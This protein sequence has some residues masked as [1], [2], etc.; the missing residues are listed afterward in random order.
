MEVGVISDIL[1]GGVAIGVLIISI[2]ALSYVIKR[3]MDEAKHREEAE[4]GIQKELIEAN[5]KN[6]E[7]LQKV[8]D[9]INE[10]N[11]LNK[12]LSEKNK[13]LTDL[14]ENKLINICDNIEY[15]K[16]Y[17]NKKDID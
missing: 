6:S 15:I 13:I 5:E 3:I 16:S 11:N 4:R 8:A 7:A 9:T 14:I 1:N 17:I 12:E 2:W 10:A